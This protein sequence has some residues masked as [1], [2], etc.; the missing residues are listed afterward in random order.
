MKKLVFLLIALVVFLVMPI[1]AFAA[2]PKPLVTIVYQTPEQL[3]KQLG[4]CKVPAP[5][6][7]GVYYVVVKGKCVARVK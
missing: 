5:K 1:I 2:A 7:H 6:G 4:Y 3:A